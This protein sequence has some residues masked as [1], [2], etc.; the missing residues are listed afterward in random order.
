MKFAT[1][2]SPLL[3]Y[4][5]VAK[6]SGKLERQNQISEISYQKFWAENSDF[7]KRNVQLHTVKNDVHFSLL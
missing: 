1:Q 5:Q 2:I 3:N 7:S 6:L 4:N